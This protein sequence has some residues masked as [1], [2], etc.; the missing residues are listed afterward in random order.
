M[1]KKNGKSK[2]SAIRQGIGVGIGSTLGTIA[3]VFILSWLLGSSDRTRRLA[4]T[5][6]E[7]WP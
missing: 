1:A 3:A 4:T 6:P 2:P 7:C 5:S